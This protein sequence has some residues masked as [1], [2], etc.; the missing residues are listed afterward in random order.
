MI[1]AQF[2]SLNELWLKTVDSFIENKPGIVDKAWSPRLFSFNNMMRSKTAEFDFDLGVSENY[3]IYAKWGST[4]ITNN[5]VTF[6]TNGGEPIN[7]LSVGIGMT[8]NEPI[9]PNKEF[10]VFCGWHIDA[11]LTTI[12]SVSMSFFSRSGRR[13]RMTLVG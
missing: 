10:Y 8:V 5:V 2:K 13:G 6:V 7:S 4:D 12:V 1:T 11:E 9:N 3:T